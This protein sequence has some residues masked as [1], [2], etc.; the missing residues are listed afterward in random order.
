MAT[1]SD[2]T[3]EADFLHYLVNSPHEM[4]FGDAEAATVVDRYYTP[5]VEY[6]TDG[7]R[8][9]RDRLIAHVRPARKRA[10]GVQVEVHQA[11]VSADRVAAHYT[12]TATMR[13]GHVIASEIYMFGRVAPDGRLRRIDQVTRTLAERSNTPD[14]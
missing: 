4:A 12:L 11:L 7:V 2:L 14:A 9:D 13:K 3:S 10:A 8:L 5:D 1:A 6:Y